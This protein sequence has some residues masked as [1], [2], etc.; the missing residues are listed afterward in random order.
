MKIIA[1]TGVDGVGKSTL[2]QLLAHRLESEGVSAAYL[3][4]RIVPFS[5]RLVMN[6]GRY[7][8]LRRSYRSGN[9]RQYNKE[10]KQT[11]QNRFLS[12]PYSVSIYLD[13]YFE[14]WLKLLPRLG[15]RK[16]IVADRY[17]YDT[18]ISDLAAH[19]DYEDQ[20]LSRGLDIG[21]RL[22]PKPLRTYL[23]ET[24]PEV[25]LSRK[26]DIPHIDY[27]TDRQDWYRRITDRPE[28]VVL[29]GRATPDRNVE[30]VMNDLRQSGR[31]LWEH[32]S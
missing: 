17:L 26:D 23:L 1:I 4:C 18:L 3:Y 25:S 20:Q 28:V 24:P 10:K 22:V 14:M 5:S 16:V 2:A 15:Q 32:G 7:L 8:F 13:Y 6:L 31:I 30:T 19:L 11:L 9:Y 29:D 12:W 27:I 21:F